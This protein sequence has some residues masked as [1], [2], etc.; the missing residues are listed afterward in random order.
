MLKR[1]LIAGA[2]LLATTV[3][4]LA[5][6]PVN[7]AGSNGYVNVREYP[8]LYADVVARWYNPS[9]GSDWGSALACDWEVDSEGRTWYWVE[10]TMKS[11]DYVEGWVSER[12]LHFP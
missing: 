3:G 1:L 10:M 6:V 9:H 7:A 2:A 8:S 4:S 5:C 12:V 11:G